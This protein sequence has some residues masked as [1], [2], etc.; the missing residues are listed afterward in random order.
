MTSGRLGFSRSIKL[1]SVARYTVAVGAALAGILVRLAFDR[2]WGTNFPFIFFFPAIMVSGWL[3]GFGPAVV[4]TVICAA[5]AD[6]F[7]LEPTGSWA[8]AD[9]SEPFSL[10]VL[11]VAGLLIAALT[12]A[13]R[14]GVASVAQ[15]EERLRVTLTSIGDAVIVT[16]EHGRV[17]R[18][19]A[20]AETL[21]GWSEAEALGRRLEDVFVV[22]NEQSRQPI[23]NPVDH[24]GR[25]GAV[26]RLANHTLLVTRDGR[27][28]AIEDSAAPIRIDDGTLVGAIMVF[29][30]VSA[31]RAL[32]RERTALFDS[33]RAAR[34][35]AETA[36]EQ[37]RIALEAGGMGTWEFTLGTGRVKWSAGLEAIHGYP[38]GGFPGTFDAFRSEIH[39]ED[40]ERV[41]AAIREAVER[42][43]DHYVEYRIV[44]TD[45]GVRWVEGRGQLFLDGGGNPERMV[46]ICL[47]V[48]DRRQSAERFRMAVEAAPAAMFLVDKTGT[49]VLVN[50]MTEKLFGYSRTEIVGQPIDRC[51]PTR[52]RGRHAEHRREFY[53]EVRQRPMGAGRDLHAVRKDG[54]EI[55][56]EIGL[57]P[58]ETAEGVFVLA[59]VTDISERKQAED[60]RT[61][62]LAREQAARADIERAGRL[63]DEFL[64]LLSHELRTPLNAILGYTHLLSTGALPPER[65]VHA[66]EAIQRNAQAQAR[67]IES[68]LDLS[69]I[70][71]GKLELDVTPLDLLEVIDAAVD[72]I[73]PDA[74]AKEITLHTTVPSREIRFAGDGTR[75]QQ[76]F[77]NLLTNAVK[78]TP[79]GGQITIQV[80]EQDSEVGIR[81]TDTGQG[82]AADFLPHVFDRFRQ[83]DIPSGRVRAGLGLGLAV[84][85]EIVEAHGGNVVAQSAGEGRGSTFVVTLPRIAT[86][87]GAPGR[88]AGARA[89]GPAGFLPGVEIL[90]VDDDGDVRDLLSVL[91]ESRGAGVRSVAS[92]RDALTAME[93]RLPHVLLAD[94]GMPDEDGYSLV[95]RLRARELETGR[96]PLAAIAVTAYAAPSDRDKA[97]AAG[98]DWHVVKPIDP[99]ALVGEI[100]RFVKTE[101]V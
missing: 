30:D 56:V 86:A 76:I 11:V 81:V 23:E 73:R 99:D 96:R 55:P 18:L 16:D 70:I 25:E 88:P 8:V 91:M 51:V 57:S 66:L 62:L 95:R 13:W 58:I 98:F 54:T 89:E 24:V 22:I 78:F 21:T 50:A 14:R 63:K 60:A 33:E 49:I 65:Q 27:E 59:A 17:T 5:A 3:S 47:D 38:P 19:N 20:V 9:K 2:L 48:T 69:R 84:V 41:L 52:A 40:R 85:R 34:R 67:L 26:A 1:P 74:A 64:A 75:L 53:A 43:R 42:Q 79:R 28:V 68:L 93:A 32:E 37:L 72:V 83:G 12:E 35:D 90:I 100:A 77:W 31:R 15:S 87:P 6:Y 45:G 97:L 94:I 4:T 80:T 44:R 7:W 61:Q 92:A 46:G 36:T 101:M 71:A 29:H 10:I 82:I 39:P